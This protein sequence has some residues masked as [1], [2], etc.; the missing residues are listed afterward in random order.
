MPNGV[1]SFRRYILPKTAYPNW[2]TSNTKLSQMHLT[3]DKKIEDIEGVLHV[4]FANEYI[5]SRETKIESY[6]V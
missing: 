4:D 6:P 2:S 5:V 3:I 1:I